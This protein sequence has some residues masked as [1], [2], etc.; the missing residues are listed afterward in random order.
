MKIAAWVMYWTL[1]PIRSNYHQLCTEHWYQS[2]HITRSYVLNID[3]NLDTLP[4]VVNP[5]LPSIRT[6]NIIYIVQITLFHTNRSA[7]EGSISVHISVHIL[8]TFVYT[9]FTHFYTHS[10]HISIHILC[11]FPYTFYTHFCTHSLH[12]LYTFLYTFCTHFY[13]HF[14][15]HFY[16][17]FDTYF[18]THSVHISIHILYTFLY[19]SCTH[20]HTHPVHI[21]IH[22]LYTFPYTFCIHFYTHSVHISWCIFYTFLYTF[23]THLYSP[24]KW[25]IFCPSFKIQILILCQLFWILCYIYVHYLL[26]LKDNLQ[27]IKSTTDFIITVLCSSVPR[28]HILQCVSNTIQTVLL[29]QMCWNEFAFI[30]YL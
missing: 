1:I 13:I 20:F 14:C 17:H 7:T 29:L 30:R 26:H 4:Q 21:S 15:T 10:V 6:L 12:I 8:Y 25:L 27:N 9:F 23:S 3:T 19:T 22:I 16:T 2:E 28:P 18:Y 5:I 24:S 11:T